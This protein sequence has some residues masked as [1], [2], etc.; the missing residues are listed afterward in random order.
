MLAAPGSRAQWLHAALLSPS[1]NAVCTANTRVPLWSLCAKRDPVGVP[2]GRRDDGFAVTLAA[3]H[4][5]IAAQ[6]IRNGA[7]LCRRPALLVCSGRRR[8]GLVQLGC[9]KDHPCLALARSA[10]LG[11]PELSP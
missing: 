6:L 3:S 4:C 1:T 5:G 9:Y 2:C 8:C 11:P 7:G 10:P